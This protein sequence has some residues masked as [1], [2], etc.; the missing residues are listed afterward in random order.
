MKKMILAA[1]VAATVLSPVASQAATVA[2]QTER[3]SILADN[4]AAFQRDENRS[5]EGRRG[6]EGRRGGENRGP[7]NDGQQ[8]RELGR[9]WAQERSAEDRQR[10]DGRRS[11]N[12]RDGRP[13]AQ[14]NGRYYDRN[15]DGN[16]DR[17]WD[18]NRDGNLDRRWDR[19][20]DDRLDRRWD[21]NDDERLDR[22]WDRNRNGDLDRRYDRNNDNRLDRRYDRNRDGDLDRRW[23]RNNDNRV[24]R[25]SHSW[26]N[27]RRY[28]WRGHRD[29]YRS[30]YSPGR[31]YAPY[32]G[33]SYRRFGI[34]ITIGSGFYGSRYWINDP[35]YYRLPAAH[36]PYR[37]VR[38]YDDVL[39]I[40]IR[41]GRV[42]DVINNFFW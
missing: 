17:R 30:Y 12:R 1:L 39:L 16:L 34:G 35:W 9:A 31:Y 11:D 37:W 26:R 14:Q 13:D 22:N 8:N 40:D 24:D 21:R 4:S 23:D 18:N 15:R 28:D 5:G 41:N 36:G 27:D 7:R 38:Y 10:G 3:S 20:R 19:N 6:R 2:Q 32:R 42:V 33:H 25:W 29:R